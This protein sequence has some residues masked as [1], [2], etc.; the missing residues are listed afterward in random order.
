MPI[1]PKKEKTDPLLDGEGRVRSIW[2][3][4]ALWEEIQRAAKREGYST[5]KFATFLLRGGFAGYEKERL[6]ERNA[7]DETEKP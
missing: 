7:A 2:T 4:D 1:V 3:P 5:S 6:A